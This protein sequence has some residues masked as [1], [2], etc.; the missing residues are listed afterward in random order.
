MPIK[1]NW[2]RKSISLLPDNISKQ[3]V[4]T[5]KGGQVVGWSGGW[6]VI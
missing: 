6:V 5:Q 2:Q 3:A 4:M 1:K